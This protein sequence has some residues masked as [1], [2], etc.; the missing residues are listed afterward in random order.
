MHQPIQIIDLSLSFP[1]KTCFE[2]FSAQILFGDRI[3]I[4]GRNGSGK[5]SLLKVI[6]SKNSNESLSYIPQ[7]ID[8]FNELSGGERF[9]KKLS[10]ALSKYP[11]IF[12][13]DE[14]TNHLDLKNRKSLMRMLKAYYG[15]LIIA[16]HDKELLHSCINILWHIDG[17]RIT[18][19]RGSYDD[20]IREKRIKHHSISRKINAL[21]HDRN[22]MH[23]SLMKEQERVSQSIKIGK[24]KI[25]NKKWMKSAGDLKVMKAEKSQGNRLKSIDEKKQE[26]LDRLSEIRLPEIITPKF[27]L[28][29]QKNTKRTIVSI[30][31]GSVGYS[32]KVVLHNIN[33]SVES[34]EHVAIIGNNGSGKTTLVR[35]IYADLM[36]TRGG[37][38]VVPHPRNIGYLDQR[39]GNLDP[40]KSAVEIIREETSWD[41]KE[42]RGFLNDFL[43]RKNEEANAPIK[44]LSEGEKARL[45]L[46]KIAANPPQ[47]LILDEITN[48]IDLETRD[49]IIEILREYRGAM[50]VISHDE[51]FL[52]AAHIERR[53]NVSV[54]SE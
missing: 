12:L 42:V 39:Y 38:W 45:S 13:L 5:S 7:I 9:N 33:L 11:S 24:Q 31:N 51:F 37:Y 40:D 54:S 22:A 48:N 10:Q 18:V 20:Y 29:C 34:Q 15:T 26:L 1:H 46:A 47:L 35:A 43:F 50:L 27:Y 21:E 44:A 25:A 41:R 36:V 19:F 6:A 23:K 17:G 3:A 49:H 30:V 53:L 16:T 52:V 4:I 8:D 14:P 28:P 32:D 2:N